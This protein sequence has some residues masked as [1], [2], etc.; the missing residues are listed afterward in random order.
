MRYLLVICL[1][2][3]LAACSGSVLQ[4]DNDYPAEIK[5]VGESVNFPTTA[6]GSSA[7]NSI[8]YPT[9]AA[10]LADLKGKP[11]ADVR[12]NNGWTI[13]GIDTPGEH[14][15]WSFTPAGHPAHPAVVK[16]TVYEENGS[17]MM[18][19]NALCQAQKS[20]CDQLMAEFAE[21]QRKIQGHM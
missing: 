13:I 20:A 6:A 10:A 21:L 16:R 12:D 4:R 9:V 15:L 1:S 5:G 17:V 19:T 14:S 8:G 3:L 11:E 18:K 7:A 2:F